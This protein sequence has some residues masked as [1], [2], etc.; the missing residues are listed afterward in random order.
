MDA[1][2]IESMHSL[3]DLT[4]DD[5]AKVIPTD[6]SEQSDM[7]AFARRIAD[8]TLKQ[9]L[10]SDALKG[11]SV[12]QTARE[13]GESLKTDVAMG[14]RE[15]N[16]VQHKF[17]FAMKPTAAQATL[18]YSGLTNARLSYLASESKMD[19]EL[20]EP[21]DA[22]STDLVFNHVAIPGDTKEVMSLSWA[23]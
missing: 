22:L 1:S 8:K 19:L 14:S 5:V 4:T 9:A 16:S 6:M 20:R 21:V 23:W 17:N 15:P 7:G 13:V 11:S 3:R 18:R 2:K 10:E 12:L